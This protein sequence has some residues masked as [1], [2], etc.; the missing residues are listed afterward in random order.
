[1]P[2]WTRAA[3]EE[4]I[5]IRHRPHYSDAMSENARVWLLLLLV[6][7]AWAGFAGG[8]MPGKLDDVAGSIA[9]S[10]VVKVERISTREV[11]EKCKRIPART[12]MDMQCLALR[13]LYGPEAPDTLHV[14]LTLDAWAWYDENCREQGHAWLLVPHSG[15]EYELK[16]GQ[17]Y[18]FSFKDSAGAGSAEAPRELLRADREQDAHA[19]QDAVWQAHRTDEKP[20]LKEV[21]QAL[22]AEIVSLEQE[23]PLHSQDGGPEGGCPPAAFDRF[24]RCRAIRLLAGPPL[25]GEFKVSV[26]MLNPSAEC[27]TRKS[28]ILERG[29]DAAFVAE[30]ELKV[31]GRYCF[32][33]FEA[34]RPE[35]AAAYLP[36]CWV[37]AEGRADSLSDKIRK[38][39]T[40]AG[41]EARHPSSWAAFLLNRLESSCGRE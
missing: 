31:G 20:I 24:Y 14:R 23:N 5:D 26:L 37:D 13:T 35:D 29:G 38:W 6:G 21:A 2:G 9:Q 34:A 39:R 32:L 41:E 27:R 19:V 10:V 28:F 12:Y 1:M 8:I 3:D 4:R 36:A 16:E 30:P 15:I 22:V 11:F 18:V 7:I 40:P 25:S 17:S 33:S